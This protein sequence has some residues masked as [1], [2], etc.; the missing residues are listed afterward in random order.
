MPPRRVVGFVSIPAVQADGPAARGRTQQDELDSQRTALTEYVR[1]RGWRLAG[2]FEGELEPGRKH[3]LTVKLPGGLESALE[4]LET[5]AASALVV[6]RLDRLS[7]YVTDIES[8]TDW[9]ASRTLSLVA[10][11]EELDTTRP[12]G[13][14]LLGAFV[15]GARWRGEMHAAHI[16]FGRARRD[17]DKRPT[18][19]P[20][21]EYGARISD[22]PE[23]LVYI[24][25]LYAEGLSLRQIARR[26][27]DEQIETSRG[28]HWW[29][30][31]TVRSALRYPRPLREIVPD[32]ETDAEQGDGSLTPEEFEALFRHLLRDDE[33]EPQSQ[34]RRG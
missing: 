34:P 4:A 27:E 18:T 31:S 30:P 21:A 11:A 29:W 32:E 3:R 26:L 33:V 10:I 12:G 15:R 7:P 20:I 22:R 16:R 6:E 1:A 28:G 8:V 13:R 2:L 24:H 9:L 19:A 23:L 14:E 17:A 5:T 25:E